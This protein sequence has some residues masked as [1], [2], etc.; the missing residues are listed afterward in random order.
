MFVRKLKH[1]NGKIYI[2]AVEKVNKKYVVRSSF[3]SAH[4]ENDLEILGLKAE[5][6]IKNYKGIQEIDF[7]N[8][9]SLYSDFLS[10][11]TS[12][13]GVGIDLILGKIFDEIGFDQI[14]DKLF[15]DLVLYR[16]VYPKSKLKRRNIYIDLHKNIIQK[17]KYIVIWTSYSTSKKTWFSKLVMTIL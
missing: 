17:T 16:L 5:K 6:W 13:K 11:I 9:R 14:E 10:S 1:K 3:G 2:Q 12:Y 15:K 4:S 7:E 8:E